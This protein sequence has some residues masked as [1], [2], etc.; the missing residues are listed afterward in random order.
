MKIA[1]V[2]QGR[3]HA[4]DLARELLNRGH[5]VTLF[6]NYPRWAVARFDVPR[7]RARGFLTHGLLSRANQQLPR[8][9]LAGVREA[10]LHRLFGRWASAEL[11]KECWDIVHVWSGVAEE[12]LRTLRRRPGVTTL[13]MRGS[14]HIR[15]QDR[16]LR[17]EEAR[18]GTPQD[19]PSP[20]MVAR[21]EREYE[22]ADAVVVLST[23]SYDTFVAEGIPPE[24][25]RLLPLGARLSSF[26]PSS[27][28]VEARRQ[29][30]LSGAPLR[31]LYVGSVSFRKGL[32]D[33]VA[34]ARSVSQADIQLRLVGPRLAETA[35]IVTDL[36]WWVIVDGKQPQ[37]ALPDVYAWADLFVFPTI[38][39]GYPAV[40]AQ[41]AASGL[42]ILTTPNGSGLDL[43]C[44]GDT[45]WIVPIRSPE[46][47]VERLRWCATHRA[48]LA[49]M[50]G[51]VYSGYRPRDWADVAADFEALCAPATLGQM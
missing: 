14:A 29:R 22:L 37:R 24:R 48:E 8:Q 40:M 19:R 46:R 35:S 45:G 12:A 39:D 41:A 16:L 6:T 9:A 36:P 20:W 23:F 44:E 17:E 4:F 11:A 30:I 47:L 33:L 27:D 49:A 51:H 28:V 34:V 15:A 10:G 5:D 26:R 13:L 3:F 2:V 25:L 38:E 32:W 42:P 43:V 31:V 18:T 1:L 21:E 7:D 50:V